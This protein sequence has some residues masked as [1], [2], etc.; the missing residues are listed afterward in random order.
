MH[1]PSKMDEPSKVVSKK[2]IKLQKE[3]SKK[4]IQNSQKPTK[5]DKK[6]NKKRKRKHCLGRALQKI[7]KN[8]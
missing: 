4:N 3:V 7:S 5:Q 2:T 8:R 1:E 6:Q